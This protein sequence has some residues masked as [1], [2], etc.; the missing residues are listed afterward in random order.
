V[1]TATAFLL[2]IVVCAMSGT[3]SMVTM[4]VLVTL[5]RGLGQSA[6]SVISLT[7]VGQ[8]FVSKL[9]LAMGV[10][11]VVMSIG[12][13]IAFPVV[14]AIVQSRG[15]RIAWLMTGLA[16]IAVLAP[17][18]WAFARDRSLP[19]RGDDVPILEGEAAAKSRPGWEWHAAVA[20]PS[21]WVFAIGSGLY[22]LV[23]SGIGLF[24]ESILAERGFDANVYYQTLVVTAM[25]ALVGNFIGGLL[26]DRWTMPRLMCAAMAI[27]AAGLTVLPV[28]STKTQVM[29]WAAAMGLGG[30]FVMV[31]FFGYWARAYGQRQLGRIQGIAQAVTVVASAVGPVLLAEWL[32]WTGSYASMFTMLAVVVALNGVAALMIR[33]PTPEEGRMPAR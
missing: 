20:T 13:M 29:L 4:A 16:L 15:W 1:L 9:E 17:L 25:F 26:A 24:N 3:T 5:T 30:G 18:G 21:F 27:L 6:L 10:F 31:L 14:G 2:G 11:A 19:G 23:A 28:A 8:A 7:M 12:F 32:A 33:M 22:A